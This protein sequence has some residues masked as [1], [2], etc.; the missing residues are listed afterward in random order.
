MCQHPF[1]SPSFQH[2]A[3]H[4]LENHR[5]SRPRLR[6]DVPLNPT[7]RIRSVPIRQHPISARTLVDDRN[8]ARGAVIL[9]RRQHIVRPSVITI[10]PASASVRDTIAD[11]HK[12][13]GFGGGPRLQRLNEPPMLLRHRV[14]AR[15]VLRIDLVSRA[16]PAVHPAARVPRDV[17]ARL[18][19]LKVNG[20]GEFRLRG[21]VEVQWIRDGKP[22]VG[23][24]DGPV[25]AEGDV[26][27]G[28]G[29]DQR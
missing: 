11:D 23:Y 2:Q 26:L 3:T 21:D 14:R 28:R 22:L 6:D 20:N 19:V 8:I 10:I 5:E 24:R 27:D 1:L 16:V 7:Q 25:P 13:G 4:P 29:L 15:D 12:A 17:V 18:A 9:H